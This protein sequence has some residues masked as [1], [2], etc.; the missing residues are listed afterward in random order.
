[1]GLPG[2]LPSEVSRV[3]L[4]FWAL[5]LGVRSVSFSTGKVILPFLAPC[6]LGSFHSSLDG[7]GE[8]H[9]GPTVTRQP[10][11]IAAFPGFAVT[12]SRQLLGEPKDHR[13]GRLSSLQIC[14]G[15]L[16]LFGLVKSK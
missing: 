12:H 7:C 8:G 11:R 9:T 14:Q 3:L 16:L 13:G 5:V 4:L 1:M 15:P 2:D 6:P 10:L